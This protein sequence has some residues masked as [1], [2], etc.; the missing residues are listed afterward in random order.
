MLG[1]GF[2][3]ANQSGVVN[4]LPCRQP[5]CRVMLT[6]PCGMVRSCCSRKTPSHTH[7]LTALPR[8]ASEFCPDLADS[9]F[10]FRS[11]TKISVDDLLGVHRQSGSLADSTLQ[12]FFYG[13]RKPS[14]RARGFHSSTNNI[15]TP[16]TAQNAPHSRRILENRFQAAN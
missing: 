10:F 16:P 9:L 8:L 1:F 4:P 12:G 7:T 5:R 13:S 3:G 15:I 2:S 14:T 6:S 11:L